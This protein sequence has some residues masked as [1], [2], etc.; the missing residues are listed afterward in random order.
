MILSNADYFAEIAQGDEMTNFQMYAWL[1]GVP[2]IRPC[3]K[4]MKGA[5]LSSKFK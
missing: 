3:V 2:C 5:V 1:S 4:Y